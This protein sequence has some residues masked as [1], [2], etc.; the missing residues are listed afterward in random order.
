MVKILVLLVLLTSTAFADYV[1]SPYPTT[2]GGTGS[3]TQS[4][5]I[6]VTTDGSGNLVSTGTTTATELANVHGTTSAIQTQLNAKASTALSN[7][8]STA[9]NVDMLPGSGTLHLG[10]ASFPWLDSTMG[11]LKLLGSTSGTLSITGA[12]TITT[13]SLIMP[14]AQ[15]TGVLT[16]DGAGNLSWAAALTNALA[17]GDVFFGVGGVATAT[18]V[19]GLVLSQVLTGYSAGTGT[20]SSADT[21]IFSYREA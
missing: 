14:A 5:N 2:K 12:A 4:A 21:I 8:A 9:V 6:A 1:A 20:I 3:A 19:N 18:P 10:N 7:L 15:G 11:T 17:S 16:N 13:Y